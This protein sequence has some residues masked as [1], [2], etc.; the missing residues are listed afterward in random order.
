ML[1]V[2]LLAYL[3]KTKRVFIT[4]SDLA[5]FNPFMMDLNDPHS[6]KL[7]SLHSLVGFMKCFPSLARKFYSNCDKKLMEI[8]VPYLK[9]AVSPAILENEIM[10]IEMS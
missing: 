1:L 5:E 10:K 6:T 9:Q 8:V 7:M 2:I 3:P 4:A